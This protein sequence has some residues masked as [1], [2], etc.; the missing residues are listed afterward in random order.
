MFT[1]AGMTPA[2]LVQSMTTE[3]ARLL[4]VADRRGAIRP[5]MAADI[6]ATPLNPLED[7]QTLKNVSFVMKDGVIV[8]GG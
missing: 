2:H 7:A 6:V 8:R 5:G 4:G 1:E 3:A